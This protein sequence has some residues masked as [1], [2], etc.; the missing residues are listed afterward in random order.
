VA[1]AAPRYDARI[2]DAVEVLDDRSQPMAET[3]RRVAAVA[4]GLGLARPSTVHLR[5]YIRL[6][7]EEQDAE[8]ERREFVREFALE[9][10][11]GA[12]AGRIPNAYV[13]EERVRRRL[14]G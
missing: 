7:R 14:R 3:C 8:R 10:A 11:A 1:A 9:M 4:E 2:L 5:T 6:H 12:A 13:V